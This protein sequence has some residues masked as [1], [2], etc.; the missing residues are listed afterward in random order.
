MNVV[1]FLTPKR[2]ALLVIA[3]PMAAA[4]AYYSV[5]AADRYVSESIVTVRQANEAGGVIPGMAMLLTGANPP[6]RQDNLYLR[7]Y[8][9]SLD[10]MKR[11]D[12]RLG[13]RQHY[14][15]EK[16]DL[17]FRLFHSSSRERFLDYYRSRVDVTYDDAASLLSVHTEGFTPEFAYR[18]NQAILR[19]SEQFV[20]GFSHLIARV[21][22]DFN[23]SELER[24]SERLQKA[25]S[26]VLAFQTEHRLLDPNAQ[27]KA[28]GVLNTELQAALSK[29]E[30][31][32]TSALGYLNEDSYQ[33][34]ALRTQVAALR[35]Q[36]STES[37]RATNVSF[38]G[39]DKLNELASKF[40]DLTLQAQFSQEAYKLTLAAVENA[41]IDATRKLKSLVVIEPP[42]APETAIYPR[43][44]YNLVTLF[45]VCLLLYA[46]SRLVVA[47][48]REHQD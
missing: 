15:A 33:V 13:L 1:K 3:L 24:S 6:S 32:L 31:E 35:S 30:V 48:V 37:A 18:L 7:E 26:M 2:L 38:D 40:Q 43:R 36:M 34:K 25:K 41:R 9:R 5:F 39:G 19:D 20:N 46:I 47:T 23:N 12:A 10:L 8:M 22:L 28:A 29:Q 4:I 17:V 27:A 14:E 11:L 16:L 45:V 44:L 42:S 21:Q